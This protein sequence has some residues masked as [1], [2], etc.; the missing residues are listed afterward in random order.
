MPRWQDRQNFVGLDGRVSQRSRNRTWRRTI[1]LAILLA[2]EFVD[3][4]LRRCPLPAVFFFGPSS[5]FAHR[6]RYQKRSTVSRRDEFGKNFLH[7]QLQIDLANDSRKFFYAFDR[8]DLFKGRFKLRGEVDFFVPR[9]ILAT[10][11]K[12]R[13]FARLIELSMN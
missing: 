1:G 12:L 13:F 6:S 3:A 7:R 4:A 8:W 10:S 11:M 5:P 9:T 2:E